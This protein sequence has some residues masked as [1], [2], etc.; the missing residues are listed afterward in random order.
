V[1]PAGVGSEPLGLRGE[2]VLFIF[3]VLAGLVLI[4]LLTR[5]L[6]RTTGTASRNS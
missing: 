6:T 3:L 2:D 1:R 4:A 5:R